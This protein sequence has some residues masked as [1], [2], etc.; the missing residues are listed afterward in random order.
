MAP[1]VLSGS[2]GSKA[3]IFSM[4]VVLYTLVSGYLPFQGNKAAE[5]FRKIKT[6]DFHFNHVEF[7][8]VSDECKDLIRK[9][10]T[11]NEKQRLTGQQALKHPWFNILV[12]DKGVAAGEIKIEVV[13]RLKNFKGVS[14]FKKAAM[15]LI[16]KTA[17]EDDVRDLKAQFQAIDTDG[18]G[19]IQAQELQDILVRKQMNMSDNE[20]R[21][22]ISQMDYHNNQKINYT[23][24]L[25]A[26]L[27]VKNFLTDSKLKALFQ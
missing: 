23:E 16:V 4:G 13:N 6:G 3:D 1:E 18:T 11:T 17:S 15:N 2:Y 19:M 24:F 14:T 7:N 12:S 21:E 20:V 10:L 8:T 27:D 5:V 9:L 22:I 25:A 26:T